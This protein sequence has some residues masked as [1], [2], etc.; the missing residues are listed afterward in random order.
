MQDVALASF[1]RLV[2]EQIVPPFRVVKRA[3]PA[4]SLEKL[5]EQ[6]LA[7]PLSGRTTL[8]GPFEATRGFGV[9]FT[10]AG[11][12]K[13]EA[14]FPELVPFVQLALGEDAL[15]SLSPWP[16]R[17][18]RKPAPPNAWYLNLLLVGD[19]A[20]VTRHIDATLAGTV[21]KPGTT[22]VVVSVLYLDVPQRSGG[23]LVLSR[24]E[25][26]LGVVTPRARTLVHFDGTLDHAVAPASGI[27]EGRFRASLVLEQYRL[28]EALL[29]RVPELRVESGAGFGAF[30]QDRAN[31]FPLPLGEGGR[32]PGEG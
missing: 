24:G 14:R 8:N 15:R 31:R 22:P 1:R 16:A 21:E 25:R 6:V 13:L 3:I 2:R 12:E 10:V 30:L 29:A 27:P 5:R 7:S 17:L 19:G 26:V 4:L 11:R 9:T 20:Q 28:G 32:R 18:W 23:E